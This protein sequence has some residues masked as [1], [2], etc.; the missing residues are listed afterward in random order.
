V[1]A[2]E[3]DYNTGKATIGTEAGQAVPLEEI[4]ASLES[5]GY[6]GEFTDEP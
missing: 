2:V 3:V 6:S 1:L 4:A 5:I